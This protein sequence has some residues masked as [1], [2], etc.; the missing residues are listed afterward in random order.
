MHYSVGD[1]VRDT[2]RNWPRYNQSG[3]VVSVQ[4][5]IITWRSDTD[6]QLVTD[7]IGDMEKLMART[8]KKRFKRNTNRFL[9]RMG[10]IDDGL[11][12]GYEDDVPA[13][14]TAGE[15]DI[16]KGSVQRYGQR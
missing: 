11:G 16:K 7:P 3:T 15:Y 9:R 5:D 13:M 1:R 10:Y 2:R 6:N 12:N 8:R 4:N 14:L